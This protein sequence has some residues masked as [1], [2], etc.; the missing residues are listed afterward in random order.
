MWE[1]D[2][3]AAAEARPHG[4]IGHH[5]CLVCVGWVHLQHS[6]GALGQAGV[7]GLEEAAEP[8]AGL[9][10]ARVLQVWVRDWGDG[11]GCGCRRASDK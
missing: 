6:P 4:G 2:H 11:C 5:C 8:P 9:I 3:Q 1:V 7:E 10:C